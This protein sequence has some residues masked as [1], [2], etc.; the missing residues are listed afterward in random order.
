[1]LGTCVSAPVTLICA[2]RHILEAL[3]RAKYSRLTGGRV[4]TE[5][6][7]AISLSVIARVLPLLGLGVAVIVNAAWIAFLGYWIFRLV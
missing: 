5:T 4:V 2:L 7:K 3:R 6:G 1:M